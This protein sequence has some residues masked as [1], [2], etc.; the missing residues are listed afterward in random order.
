MRGEIAQDPRQLGHCE[1]IDV[2]LDSCDKRIED[3]TL[4][5]HPLEGHTELTREQEGSTYN[6]P[7][8]MFDVCVREDLH[9]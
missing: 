9:Q 5:D 3:L 6:G 4:H 8:S 2:S 7:R 1:G